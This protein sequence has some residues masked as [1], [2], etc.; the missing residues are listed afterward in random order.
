[1]GRQNRTSIQVHDSTHARL[2]DLKPYE[3]MSF[4]ELL[5]EMADQFEGVE[6]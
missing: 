5:N 1:M 4:D 2:E 3:T 6:A